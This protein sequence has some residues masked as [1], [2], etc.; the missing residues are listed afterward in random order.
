MITFLRLCIHALCQES[1]DGSMNVILLDVKNCKL[2]LTYYEKPTIEL[3]DI[4]RSC[5]DDIIFQIYFHHVNAPLLP[6]AKL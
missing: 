1:C 6:R 5:F 4:I 3:F 2:K